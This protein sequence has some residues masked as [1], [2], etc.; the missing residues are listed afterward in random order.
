MLKK[1]LLSIGISSALILSG[2]ASTGNSGPKTDAQGYP[3]LEVLSSTHYVWDDTISEA[4]N[5]ARMAQPARVGQGM[6]D[7]TDGTQAGVAGRS[8]T[9]ERVAGGAIMGVGQGLFGVVASEM[10]I[11][12]VDR[13]MSWRPAIVELINGQ[14]FKVHGG[15][16]D[17]VLLRDYVSRKV[18]DSIKEEYENISFGP[19]MTMRGD[20]NY[21]TYI[22]VKGDICGEIRNFDSRRTQ[23]VES[24]IKNNPSHHFIDGPDEIME[25]CFISMNISVAGG[26]IIDDEY[27]DVIVAELNRGALLHPAIIRNYKGY[28]LVPEVYI[29]NGV[30]LTRPYAFLVS[31]G[32]EILFQRP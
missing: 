29:V 23:E 20:R 9:G 30:R 18:M 1:I 24:F 16:W 13:E 7:F 19:S 2:C 10:M 12:R 28:V 26:A 11:G 6:R 25:Y 22:M 4:L 15:G 31:N 21:N 8:S 32:K 17:F 3:V 27:R 5:V 14:D